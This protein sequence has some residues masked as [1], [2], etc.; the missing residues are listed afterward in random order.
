MKHGCSNNP[1]DEFPYW[2]LPDKPMSPVQT[3]TDLSVNVFKGGWQDIDKWK[4]NNQTD[5][6]KRYLE[7]A[8]EAG[9]WIEINHRFFFKNKE[10]YDNML[11]MFSIGWSEQ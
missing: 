9:S 10:D 11:L 2:I 1:E 5:A 6:L 3:S 8:L 7:A 4:L